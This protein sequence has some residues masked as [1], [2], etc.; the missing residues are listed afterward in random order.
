MTSFRTIFQPLLVM[1]T[2]VFVS[3]AVLAKDQNSSLRQLM[4]RLINRHRVLYG[5]ISLFNA[6]SY[7]ELTIIVDL[8]TN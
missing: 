1:L 7:F 2:P 5:F 6:L 8:N 3:P 4:Q